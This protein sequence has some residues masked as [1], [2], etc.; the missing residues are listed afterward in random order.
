M[1]SLPLC[2]G[3]LDVGSGKDVDAIVLTDVGGTNF[4]INCGLQVY[5]SSGNAQ[6]GRVRLK[7]TDVS[8]ELVQIWLQVGH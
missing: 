1:A 2:N 6:Q 4:G 7:L 5:M 8:S 3:L